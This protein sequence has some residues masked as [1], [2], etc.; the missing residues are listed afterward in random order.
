M[1]KEGD[2]KGNILI[3]E[4]VK[5]SGSFNVPGKAMV[6]GSL[7]GELVA[8]ELTVGPHGKL[9]GKVQ[10]RKADVHGE[11]HD[12]I[13]AS[14]YLI[15]RSTGQIHGVAAYGKIEIERGG[16]IT[17]TI[18]PV[19]TTASPSDKPAEPGQVP[20]LSNELPLNDS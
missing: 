9:L 19:S 15:I 10:V 1:N 2:Q 17:G 16:V 11:S 7:D 18:A 4:G 3:G 6:N 20:T 14:E 12:S 5:A 8:D 13:T